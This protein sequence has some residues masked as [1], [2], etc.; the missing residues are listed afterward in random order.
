MVRKVKGRV[1]CLT[2]GT[3]NVNEHL[4]D[5][6]TCYACGCSIDEC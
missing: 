5:F 1:K 3:M 6:L 4:V 2:C